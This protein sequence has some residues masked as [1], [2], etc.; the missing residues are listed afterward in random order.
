[1]ARRKTLFAAF[2]KDG[3]PAINVASFSRSIAER[4]VGDRRANGDAL[5]GEHVVQCV[6]EFYRRKLRAAGA[7]PDLCI[8]FRY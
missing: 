7:N 4:E 2:S 6:I 1:M 5:E 3:V 8:P